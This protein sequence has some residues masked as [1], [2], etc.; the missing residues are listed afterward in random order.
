M[1]SN[2]RLPL[3]V[4]FRVWRAGLSVLSG[5][6]RAGL[7][8]LS[9]VHLDTFIFDHDEARVDAFDLSDKLLLGYRSC[10]WLL[11]QLGVLA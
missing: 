7:S 8:V 6:W 10:L 1:E 11:D 2:E 4:E 3:F 5:V 9:G